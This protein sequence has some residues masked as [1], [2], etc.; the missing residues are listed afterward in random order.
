M[1]E[2]T[3]ETNNESRADKFAGRDPFAKDGEL[4]ELTEQEQEAVFALYC[5]NFGNIS[6]LVRDPDNG[7]S[8]SRQYLGEWAKRYDWYSRYVKEL[9][10]KIENDQ[11]IIRKELRA[12]KLKAIK[13]A[14]WLLNTRKQKTLFFGKEVEFTQEPSHK[15]IK[16]AYE[17]LK[18][19]L[20]E[21][22]RINHNINQHEND[23]ETQAVLDF[24]NTLI[25]GD[26]EQ[27]NKQEAGHSDAKEADAQASTADV[28]GGGAT[29]SDIP[30]LPTSI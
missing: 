10:E 22:V 21:P 8:K 7:F 29:G 24:L 11:E 17:I 20:G 5:K 9:T 13:R 1:S 30:T 28:Q 18:T 23:K 27:D 15:D 26:D 4:R 3:I 14:I 12:G 25:D 16:A 6:M 2:E 19:E